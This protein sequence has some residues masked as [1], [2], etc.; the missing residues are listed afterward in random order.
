MILSYRKF[1]EDYSTFSG[2]YVSCLFHELSTI[3]KFRGISKPEWAG[4]DK[5]ITI[6][7]RGRNTKN[8]T[9]S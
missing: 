8:P 1:S 4:I 6:A 9:T 7:L 2:I 5:G 3:R